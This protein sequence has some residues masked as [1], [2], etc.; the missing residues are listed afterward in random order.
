MHEKTTLCL[1]ITSLLALLTIYTVY[2]HRLDFSFSLTI[3]KDETS[4]NWSMAFL[5]TLL[6][7]FS[8]IE[9]LMCRFTK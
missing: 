8:G 4:L 1:I 7:V 5:F 9:Y 3:S 6:T 2:K